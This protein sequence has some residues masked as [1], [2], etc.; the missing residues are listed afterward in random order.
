MHFM[1]ISKDTSELF[2]RGIEYLL[3][4][5]QRIHGYQIPSSPKAHYFMMIPSLQANFNKLA[6]FLLKLFGGLIQSNTSCNTI[7]KLMTKNPRSR[8]KPLSTF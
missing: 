3:D 4:I 6:Y 2:L 7:Y 8:K 5:K 1:S